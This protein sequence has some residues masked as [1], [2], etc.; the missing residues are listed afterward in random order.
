MVVVG[1][2]VVVVEAGGSVVVD[3]VEVGVGSWSSAG[4]AVVVGPEDPG[5]GWGVTAAGAGTGT[6]SVVVTTGGAVVAGAGTVA[7]VLA[8][9]TS[10]A[11]SARRAEASS[12]WRTS[13]RWLSV[14]TC[15]SSRSASAPRACDSEVAGAWAA[16]AAVTT[17]STTPPLAATPTNQARRLRR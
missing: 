5:A 11:A 8:G 6:G 1:A 10:D 4:G 3:V 14:M 7:R 2:C 17:P 12:P 16:P 9:D 13:S 15:W